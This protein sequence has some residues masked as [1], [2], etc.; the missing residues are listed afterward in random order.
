ETLPQLLDLC[1]P[2][3]I[4]PLCSPTFLVFKENLS[5]KYNIPYFTEVNLI[6]LLVANPFYYLF[7]K[8]Y[9]PNIFL[10]KITYW[11]ISKSPLN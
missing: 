8:I 11:Y 10:Q 2:I 9:I 5:N 7:K 3:D 4:F 1:N 6:T